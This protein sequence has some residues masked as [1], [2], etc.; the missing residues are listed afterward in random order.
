M[1]LSGTR[2]PAIGLAITILRKTGWRHAM[3]DGL[4]D[5]HLSAMEKVESWRPGSVEGDDHAVLATAATDDPSTGKADEI[6]GQA[7]RA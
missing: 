2:R 4:T 5:D 7:V 3:L 1:I 6:S